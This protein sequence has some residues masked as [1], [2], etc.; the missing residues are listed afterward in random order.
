M[1]YSDDRKNLITIEELRHR[2][3][4]LFLYIDY[5]SYILFALSI[6]LF[7]TVGYYKGIVFPISWLTFKLF[8][9]GDEYKSSYLF[10]IIIISHFA[11]YQYVNAIGIDILIYLST[12]INFISTCL[13][14]YSR[15]IEIRYKKYIS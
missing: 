9:S 14:I 5:L 2:L 8:A 1:N 12:F 7:H 15:T 6:C 11:L 13:W 10:F 4:R 3:E